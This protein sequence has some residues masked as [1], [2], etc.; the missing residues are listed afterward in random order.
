MRV[1]SW[2][3]EG[4]LIN[5]VMPEN[6]DTPKLI[7]LRRTLLLGKEAVFTNFV[8]ARWLAV[9]LLTTGAA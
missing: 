2:K 8:P 1:R 9:R 4:V 7:G 6:F 3:R 5:E